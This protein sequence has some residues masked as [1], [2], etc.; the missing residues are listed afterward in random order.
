MNEITFYDKIDNPMEAIREVGDMLVSSGMFG[1]EKKEQGYVLA[2]ACMCEK[3]NPLDI[4]R[5]YH[6][7]QGKLSKKYEA[8]I[9]E[10]QEQGGKITWIKRDATEVEAKF[11]HPQNGEFQLKITMDELKDSGVALGSGGKLKDNYKTYPR[12]MLT[13]R[14]VSEAMRLIAPNIVCG[15]YT[16]EEISDFTP[17]PKQSVQNEPLF[18][19]P[20]PT[21]KPKATKSTTKKKKDDI[22][23]IEVE[24]VLDF[25]DK[26]KMDI[27]V[28][29][30]DVNSF[31]L[32][33]G[34]I[35]E[36][37]T[38]KDLNDINRKNVINGFDRFMAKVKGDK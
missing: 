10:F 20:K 17:A 23:E 5:Q 3:K 21:K 9:A 18:S 24:A 2:M 36:G 30:K 34:F 28:N 38:W 35:K 25:N 13:A 37:Q 33:I 31:L 22:K 8:M 12:Q 19:E 15:I 29:E 6:I 14:V 11:V 16:P 32:K 26:Q 7:V 27:M 4:A 1:C